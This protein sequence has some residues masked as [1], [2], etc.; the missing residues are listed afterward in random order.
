MGLTGL[1]LRG[2]CED[3]NSFRIPLHRRFFVVGPDSSLCL[4]VLSAAGVSRAI[5]RGVFHVIL[6]ALHALHGE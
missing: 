2:F 5:G 1:G 4:C 3:L 6:H